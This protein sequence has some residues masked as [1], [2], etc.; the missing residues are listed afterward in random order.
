MFD[1][2]DSELIPMSTKDIM[3]KLIYLK[4]LHGNIVMQFD[5]GGYPT[6]ITHSDAPNE[7]FMDFREEEETTIN[8][9]LNQIEEI[10]DA[11]TYFNLAHEEQNNE[12]LVNREDD[13]GIF[14]NHP[15]QDMYEE[16]NIVKIIT[17]ESLE[18]SIFNI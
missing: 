18:L 10:E 3:D 9:I 12:V 15:I 7:F 4:E 5:F 1:E 2:I 13:N 11:F 6:L 14:K 17:Q 8:R 16:D